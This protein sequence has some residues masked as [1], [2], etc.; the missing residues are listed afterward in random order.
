MDYQPQKTHRRGSA[1][2]TP[3]GP[4]KLTPKGQRTRARI[5]DVAAQLIWEHGVTATTLEGV[6]LAAKVS[7]SQLYHYFA[8]KE[9]LVDAV[10]ERQADQVVNNAEQAD[11][12]T[13]ESLAAWRDLVVAHAS[14][15]H[16]QRGCPLGA[17]GSQLAESDPQARTLVAAG[18]G[19][20][21]NAIQDGMRSLHSQGHLAAGI[22][23]DDLAITVLAALQGGLLLAQVHRDVRPLQTTLETILTMAGVTGPDGRPMQ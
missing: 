6:K 9:R 15:I 7:S 3:T 8:D 5:I 1:A 11:L 20:W 19:R 14:A 10:I 12:G 2:T 23:P 17:L 21:A 13:A 16:G 4:A 22:D 18:F